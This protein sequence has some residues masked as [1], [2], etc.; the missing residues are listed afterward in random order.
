MLFREGT[1]SH[2]E[3]GCRLFLQVEPGEFM[4]GKMV[5]DVLNKTLFNV[6]SLNF[7][8]VEPKISI[9]QSSNS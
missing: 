9:I 6:V 7:L 5:V 1:G 3:G 4:M 8:E 2:P